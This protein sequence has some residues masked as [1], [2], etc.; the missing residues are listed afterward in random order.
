MSTEEPAA[1]VPVYQLKVVLRDCSPLIWRRL[2][3]SS[4]TTIA[5]LHAILQTALG[6]EDLHLHRFRIH[7]KEYGIYREVVSSLTTTPAKSNSPLSSCGP[8][9]DSR[10]NMTWGISGSMPSTLNKCCRAIPTRPSR[11]AWL[12]P[13]TVRRRIAVDLRGISA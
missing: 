13:A 3:V 12:A 4:D 2:L 1:N 8:A 9:N 10:M 5:H 7:S 11:C 6:W